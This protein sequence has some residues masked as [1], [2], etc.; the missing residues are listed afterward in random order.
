MRSFCFIIALAAA[1][2][3]I[4]SVRRVLVD[5]DEQLMS[6]CLF[7]LITYQRVQRMTS[8]ILLILIDFDRFLA[9]FCCKTTL[10]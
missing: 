2:D 9:T 8:Q 6:Y 4:L 7:I 5:S 10:L 1:Q 3:N